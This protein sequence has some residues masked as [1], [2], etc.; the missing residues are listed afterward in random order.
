MTE[1]TV[2]KEEK[3]VR[4]DKEVKED[5]ED[6]EERG[7]NV[8]AEVEE[9]EISMVK[10]ETNKVENAEEETEIIMKGASKKRKCM[11]IKLLEN[12]QQIGKSVNNAW[13][14]KKKVK[15]FQFRTL[16]A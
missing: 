15:D 3:E 1:E 2:G 5:R 9:I 13:L 16:Y 11:L 7:E 10:A 14:N 6:R 4:E 12:L 8:E